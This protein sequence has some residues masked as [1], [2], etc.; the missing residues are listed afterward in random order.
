MSDV[1]AL[2]DRKR[3]AGRALAVAVLAVCVAL[4]YLFWRS[5]QLHPVVYRVDGHGCEP[6]ISVYQRQEDVS[7]PRSTLPWQ[8]A[9]FMREYDEHVMLFAISSSACTLSCT[10]ISDGVPL[11]TLTSE[12]SVSCEAAVPF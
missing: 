3:Q 5:R 11:I 7:V 1:N 6:N 10:I 9:T 12:G 4:L 8:S 2:F